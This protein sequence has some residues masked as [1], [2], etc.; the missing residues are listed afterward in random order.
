MA[1]LIKDLPTEVLLHM[2][3]FLHILTIERLAKTFTH[4][5]TDLCLPILE[6]MLKKRREKARFLAR[7][8]M[9][10]NIGTDDIIPFLMAKKCRDA[11]HLTPLDR[12]RNGREIADAMDTLVLR[13]DFNWMKPL[14]AVMT[15]RMNRLFERS[16]PMEDSTYDD[17][18]KATKLAGVTLP[19]IFL[20]FIRDPELMK[21]VYTYRTDAGFRFQEPLL[22]EDQGGYFL[23]FFYDHREQR[24][25]T[26]LWLEPGEDG[27]YC[28]LTQVKPD[29]G[30]TQRF[31]GPPPEKKEARYRPNWECWLEETDFEAFLLNLYYAKWMPEMRISRA[32]PSDELRH[33]IKEIYIRKPR[34]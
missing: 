33:F 20:K 4:P 17:L 1:M 29:L 13:G 2:L 12:L 23:P 21:R 27:H 26:G 15:G 34:D 18:L 30:P 25:L 5:L 24:S 8:G 11:L 10:S 14:N 16:P 6:P 3:S 19:P 9:I 28:V 31:F 32:E 22:V 7:F